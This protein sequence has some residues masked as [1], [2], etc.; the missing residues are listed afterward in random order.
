MPSVRRNEGDMKN[1]TDINR[2]KQN[3]ITQKDVQPNKRW[4]LTVLAMSLFLLL[5]LGMITV[6]IDPYFHYHKPLS[7]LQYP[8]HDERYLNDGIVRHF[9]Y[10]AI[11][12]G[13]SLTQNFKTSELDSLFGV[14]S[15]KVAFSG[16]SYKEVNDTLVRAVHANP[17]LKLVVRA[18]D[19]GRLITHK[20][21]MY[22]AADQYPSYLYNDLLCD[23]V[24]YVLNKTVLIDHSLNAVFYTRE[25][26]TTTSF[27]DYSRWWM[28][29]E[30]V[31]RTYSRPE[32]AS[33]ATPL[34]QEDLTIIEENIRQN[35]TDLAEANP[36]IEFYLYLS[37]N[38][39]YY[40]DSLRQNGILQRQLQAEKYAVSLM[41]PYE[42]IHLFSFFEEYEMICDPKNYKDSVHYKRD[43]NSQILEWMKNGEHELTADNYEAYWERI[44]DF[45]GNY[46]YDALF[47]DRETD[48]D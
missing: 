18:L 6:V 9:D 20:D 33:E 2:R 45:Y 4:F 46:D 17:N 7:A 40:W 44:C 37:P 23:D 28:G 12:T 48:S 36:D 29:N 1:R 38:S 5:G 11:I 25:G 14:H 19:Y 31:D 47:A 26:N 22:Y 42:N 13:S 27:D 3:E 32:K 35:V 21:S 41:L 24:Q 34:S 16:G 8:L 10:D 39:I 15:V 30:Y 43:I